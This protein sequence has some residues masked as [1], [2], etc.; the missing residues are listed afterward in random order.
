MPASASNK[1]LSRRFLQVF[2]PT[3]TID[4]NLADNKALKIFSYYITIAVYYNPI[5]VFSPLR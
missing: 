3:T 4:N 5:S 2:K 1:R